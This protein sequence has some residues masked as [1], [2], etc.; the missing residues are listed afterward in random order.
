MASELGLEVGPTFFRVLPAE[1]LTPAV[2][3]VF[4]FSSRWQGPTLLIVCDGAVLTDR[5]RRRGTPGPLPGGLLHL[6]HEGLLLS[7]LPQH[8]LI[9]DN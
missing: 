1:A 6:P 5:G 7:L 8:A 2:A 9:G 4:P 3:G